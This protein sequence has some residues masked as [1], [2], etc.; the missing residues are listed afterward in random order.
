MLVLLLLCLAAICRDGQERWPSVTFAMACQKLD[1][2]L[3][4]QAGGTYPRSKPFFFVR[5]FSYRT[6]VFWFYRYVIVGFCCLSVCLSVCLV[7][8]LVCLSTC[9]SVHLSTCLSILLCLILCVCRI[10]ACMLLGV[11]CLC[12]SSVFSVCLCAC[13][14]VTLFKSRG[15]VI[16][17]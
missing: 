5:V 2:H 13:L 15:R 12:R 11:C 9:L 14:Y 4:R 1:V 10:P 6:R 7:C 3:R 17:R 8:L 16:S